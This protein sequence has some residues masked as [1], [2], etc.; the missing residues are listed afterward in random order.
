MRPKSVLKLFI[1]GGLIFAAGF[2][3]LNYF[4][5]TKT[6][7]LVFDFLNQQKTATSTALKPAEITKKTITDIEP[8][9]P[10]V[11]PPSEI[12]AIYATSW[13][14]SS[15]KKMTTLIN[16]IKSTEL[17][18]IVI[19][20]KD[21]SGFVTYDTDLDLVKKYNSKEVRMPR[22][23]ALI[24]QLHD[25]NIYAIARVAVFQDPRLALARPDLALHSSTTKKVWLDA[26][27][28]SWIDPAAEEAWDYNIAI[29]KDV[30]TRGFDEINFDYI[31]FASDGK[32]D[33]IEYPF[34][35]EV[36]PLRV[37]IK[38]FFAYLRAQLPND[39]ISA[40][41][42]GLVTVNKDDLGIGQ[43]FESALPYFNY[44]A[45]MVYPSHYNAG[46]I[47]Y[48]NPAAYPYEVIKY[49]LDSAVKRMAAYKQKLWLAAGTSTPESALPP[50]AKLRPWLQDFDLGAV[51]TP[52]M[53][54]SE[55]QA[56][57]DSECSPSSPVENRDAQICDSS[58]SLRNKFGGWM[59]WDAANNYTK[60]ALLAE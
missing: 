29:A 24:K 52:A 36:T 15:A 27:G 19:D 8:Q 54:R 40:D 9:Q 48:K 56:V 13:S 47:G 18:A 33:D 55:I 1:I 14:A 45:P 44:I 35:D 59:L 53:I 4:F 57:Y 32:L 31:R 39:V 50:I 10:L 43:Y 20:V 22:I 17:N 58:D 6:R 2:I 26:K 23:N 25:N 38:N 5:I 3:F 49:S 11:N 7:N 16:L 12:K 51:Y 41:L 30:L 21:F 28:L 46:F 34:W 37:I 42:F 60:E